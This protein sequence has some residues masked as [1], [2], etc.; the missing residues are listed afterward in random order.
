MLTTLG[1]LVVEFV[2]D[3]PL[4][5]GLV[6]VG[7]AS[8]AVVFTGRQHLQLAD[9]FPELARLPLLRRIIG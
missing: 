3:P 4:I 7:L 8:L 6:L 2:I 5:V 9:T 1:L